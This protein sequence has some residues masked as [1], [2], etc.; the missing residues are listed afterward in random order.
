M[1]NPQVARTIAEAQLGVAL[2]NEAMFPISCFLESAETELQGERPPRSKFPK[3]TV[4][5]P[6]GVTMTIADDPIPMKSLPCQRLTGKMDLRLKYGLPGDERFEL[7]F[8]A[9]VDVP[10]ESWGL[11]LQTITNWTP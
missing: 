2:K 10:I 6:A 1:I 7:R 9:T 5:I 11:H 8:P 4:V 3:P